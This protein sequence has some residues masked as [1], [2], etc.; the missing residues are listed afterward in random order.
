M[1]AEVV[2][3]SWAALP[4]GV[5]KGPHPPMTQ[6]GKQL[7][8]LAQLGPHSAASGG[9]EK[10]EREGGEQIE[11]EAT[12]W[13]GRMESEEG[14]IRQQWFLIPVSEFSVSLGVICQIQK[15]Y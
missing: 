4:G 7:P 14:K 1:L 6:R 12:F 15:V 10:R 5:G 8:L 11:L 9:T 3:A 13:G 2:K